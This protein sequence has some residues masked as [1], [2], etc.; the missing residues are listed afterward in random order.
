[1][2]GFLVGAPFLTLAVSAC[3]CSFLTA[4]ILYADWRKMGTKRGNQEN[5]HRNP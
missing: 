5:S 1:M 2:M 4:L 3:V